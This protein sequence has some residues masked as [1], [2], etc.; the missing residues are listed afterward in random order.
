MIILIGWLLGV[1]FI[2]GIIWFMDLL[3]GLPLMRMIG[4]ISNG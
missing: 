4:E 2:G 3:S 1:I